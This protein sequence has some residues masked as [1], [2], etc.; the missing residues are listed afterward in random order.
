MIPVVSVL[1]TVII[2]IIVIYLTCC[3]LPKCKCKGQKCKDKDS[4]KD[5]LEIRVEKLENLFTFFVNSN[6]HQIENDDI[7]EKLKA[8][9]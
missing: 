3:C 4:N 8:P 5:N 7:K 9:A 6:Y 1:V 2:I